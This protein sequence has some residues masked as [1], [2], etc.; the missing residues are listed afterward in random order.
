MTGSNVVADRHRPP[1]RW[2]WAGSDHP[3]HRFD[4]PSGRFR[5]RYAAS[6]PVVAARERF[7][8][9]R[10][11]TGAADP[12]LVRLD[13]PPALHLTRQVNLDAFDLDGRIDTA[14][15]DQPLPGWATRYS[16][17]V[18][19]S[20]RGLR[21]VGRDTAVDRL[22]DSQHASGSQHRVHTVIHVEPGEQWQPPDARAL[23]VSLT[24]HH[25]FDLPQTW[26]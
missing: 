8:A 19:K 4:P 26:L 9:R 15:L 10:I 22:P 16:R 14:R 11:T 25:G 21:L 6:D 24:T 3:H 12:Q 7:P 18:S 20:R 1:N 13:V 17:S 5:I 23:L 2:D